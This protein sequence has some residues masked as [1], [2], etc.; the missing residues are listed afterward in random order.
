MV[1]H[2]EGGHAEL[3]GAFGGAGGFGAAIEEGV[4]GVVV[5]V[6]KFRHNAR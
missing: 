6:Y 1:G 3:G 4:V 5:E 2:G